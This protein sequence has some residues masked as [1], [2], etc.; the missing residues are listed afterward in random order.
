MI[1]DGYSGSSHGIPASWEEG[2]NLGTPVSKESKRLN[3]RS[4]HIFYIQILAQY[5]VP[6]P[7]IV[8]RGLGSIVFISQDLVLG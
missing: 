8:A 4:T 7:F 6:V 5:L 2:M 1:Q 3:G